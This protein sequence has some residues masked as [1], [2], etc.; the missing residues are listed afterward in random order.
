MSNQLNLKI[1]MSA[2]QIIFVLEGAGLQWDIGHT[3]GNLEA[4]V[5]DWPNVIG[6]YRPTELIP[7]GD[8]LWKACE[9]ANLT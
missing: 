4:R 9:N 2:D 5:W 6:R 7:I 3:G 8:M 1:T